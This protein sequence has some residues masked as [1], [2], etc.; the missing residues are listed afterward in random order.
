M[1]HYLEE[2]LWIY[3]LIKNRY[4]DSDGMLMYQIN[5]FSGEIVDHKI[6]VSDFGDYI[7]NFYYL[8][9]L[10]G[11]KDVCQW[12]QEHLI[13]A[14]KRYQD[15]S[16][17]FVTEQERKKILIWDNADT[18][19]GLSTFFHLSKEGQIY[20]IVKKF[21]AGIQ[22]KKNRKG[23]LPESFTGMIHSPFARSDYIGNFTE[24]LVLLAQ[25]TG[26]EQYKT[27]AEQLITPWVECSYFKEIGL[28]PNR[29]M[30]EPIVQYALALPLLVLKENPFKR[31]TLVKANTNLLSG[32]LQLWQVASDTQKQKYKT[33][34][35]HWKNGVETHCAQEGYYFGRYN[36]V[37]QQRSEYRRP[38]PDNHHVLAFYADVFYFCRDQ[39]YL[40]LLEK[41]CRFW[42][43]NQQ[44]TGFFPESPLQEGTHNAKRAIMDSNLDL[45]I[46]LLKAAALTGKTTYF[47]AA[48]KCLDAIIHYMKR[49]YGYIEVVDIHSGELYLQPEFSY[50]QHG[51][52]Y[53]KYLTL[54]IKGLLLL[55]EV[56]QGNDIYRQDLFLIARDR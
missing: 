32:I 20:D 26:E 55:H 18:F 37:N 16:G 28:I 9:V 51:D 12:S 4:T 7:Q 44:E 1:S 50:H 53:T 15:E 10:T 5:S 39:E 46:V 54:F 40:S 27:L 35:D 38:L 21:I 22:E 31:S 34:I 14:S 30:C 48:K 13:Q 47:S 6:L 45:S 11:R 33:I 24:E 19:E 52:F 36:A 17:F 49:D 3:D 23:M 8:G 25:E 56:L 41:G 29:L 43:E 2:A 42:L